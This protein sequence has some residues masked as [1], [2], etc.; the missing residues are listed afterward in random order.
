VAVGTKGK[1]VTK[2]FQIYSQGV[3]LV[4]L[5]GGLA[6]LVGLG[7]SPEAKRARHIERG[8][9]YYQ[10][11]DFNKAE[12]EYL[13]ALRLNQNDP[14]ASR[15]LG[16]TYY[17]QGVWRKAGF[18]LRRSAKQDTNNFDL[19]L[20]YGLTCLQLRDMRSAREE[21]KY[22]LSRQPTNEEAFL[23]L[24]IA[25]TTNEMASVRQH[26]QSLRPQVG[27]SAGFQIGWAIL[28]IQRKDFQAAEASLRQ[29]VAADPKSSI[30]YSILGKLNETLTNMPAA[31][32]A[33]KMAA[34]LAPARS[35]HKLD[36]AQFKMKIGD[37]NGANQIVDGVLA[38]APDYLPAQLLKVEL[39]LSK[40]DF[41]EAESFLA[42][43]VA[44]DAFN[45]Q[46]LMLKAS[47]LM[48]QGEPGQALAQFER[49]AAV[50]SNAPQIHYNL[51]LA[52]L[53]NTNRAQA[54]A[55]LVTAVKIAPDFVPAVL[56][57]AQ[58]DIARGSESDLNQ[59]ITLLRGLISKYNRLT[60]AYTLL[61]QAYLAGGKADSA[62][63]V[64][65][66][67]I[68]VDP[69]DASHPLTLGRILLVQK[70]P[71]EA[72]Q[73][74]EAVYR[75]AP[76][77][78]PAFMTLMDLD[79]SEEKYADAEARVKLA[80]EKYPQSPEL[81][82]LA[83]QV[84]RAQDKIAQCEA[85]LQKALALNPT[86]RAASLELANLYATSGRGKEALGRFQG[87][88]DKNPKDLMAWLGIAVIQ[89]QLKD[90]QAAKVAYEKMLAINPNYAPALNNLAELYA[91]RLPQLDKALELA[92]KANQLVPQNPALTDTLGWVFYKRGEYAKALGLFYENSLQPNPAAEMYYHLGLA[93]Y[94]T[95]KDNQARA[96]LQQALLG[97]RDA[98]Q[99]DNSER[100]LSILAIDPRTADAKVVAMLEQR[101]EQ[102]PS[103]SFA[104]VRLAAIR[105]RD[106]DFDKAV[107]LY[108]RAIKV[109][110]QYAGALF[111]L[112]Q[113]YV[114]KNNN[115]KKA[116]P[117]V[118]SAHDIDPEDTLV[119]ALLGRLSLEMGEH[120]A[121][122]G[123]LQEA[124]D[125]LPR[126]AD[127]RFDLAMACYYNGR[128][129]EADAAMKSALQI[130]PAFARAEAA[131]QFVALNALYTD[132][133][134]ARLMNAQIQAAL[135][136]DPNYLPAL[137][138]AGVVHEMENRTAEARQ[139]YEKAL[140]VAPLFAPA[141][142]QLCLLYTE[143]VTDDKRAYEMVLKAREANPQDA[144]VARALGILSCRRGE[145][146]RAVPLLTECARSLTQDPVIFYY[147]GL[148]QC[149]LKAPKEGAA[150][151]RKALSLG[152]KP[153]LANEATR[154]LSGIK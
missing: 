38:K 69:K 104:L 120:K 35:T 114:A 94:A 97:I 95:G 72:R 14:L 132:P 131:K 90:Y 100:L 115:V 98:E 23:M 140:A 32:Q 70:K 123:F 63:D 142:R 101:I 154:M 152:L 83:S 93:Y 27:D 76:D 66:R 46:T 56:L 89:T 18:L 1:I 42:K 29:A 6:V 64:Y 148:A 54:R 43:A 108:E 55:S 48:N 141:A 49:L 136:S 13:N 71:A 77:Y 59:A 153:P 16:L 26:L 145:F 129:A 82:C 20:K 45:F 41:K 28:S 10:A 96:A 80:I 143:L 91:D 11:G 61:T 67:L 39:C 58:L 138:A 81:Y 130:N 112:A 34:D 9:R 135:K 24:T 4:C 31:E 44:K 134:R 79:L 19:R 30:A 146:A 128:V 75:M 106:G 127:V 78:L 150:M 125:K 21:G 119:T 116:Y 65:R 22:L 33:F 50:Y 126:Q 17:W 74:F 7:C 8:N 15:K 92:Q 137:M 85:A 117:L 139:A 53:I 144:P 111:R 68:T 40:K 103:D 57:L 51:A 122:L 62:A 5:A 60:R 99:K 25:L 107:S 105:E 37:S 151:L 86:Y 2:T 109:N 118:K 88:V 3:W 12:I 113:I 87:Q 124:S 102:T 73:V 149:Q 52:Y 47:L 133:P 147:L 84:Y 110:P 36:Y 121:A